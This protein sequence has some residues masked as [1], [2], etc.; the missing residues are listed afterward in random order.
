[1][2]VFYFIHVQDLYHSSDTNSLSNVLITQM[3]YVLELSTLLIYCTVAYISAFLNRYKYVKILN[4]VAS[5][6]AESKN[7]DDVRLK[8][9]GSL[10]FQVRYVA[11]GSLI[12]VLILQLTVNATRDDSL[13]KM[14]MVIFSFILPQMIQMI[15]LAFHYILVMM[16]VA[17]LADINQQ[18]RQLTKETRITAPDELYMKV[19]AKGPPFT[20]RRLQLVY[21]KAYEIKTDINEAFQA[22]LLISTLQCFHCIVSESY[23]IYHGLVAHTHTLHNTVNNSIWTSY[24]VMKVFSLAYSGRQLT[25]EASIR[26][27]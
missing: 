12:F 9:L 7:T 20:V 5:I 18:L 23:S 13:W 21:S 1:M 10:N 6:L 22:P 24:Q 17:L 14:T 16:L 27:S 15:G 25:L 11:M 8:I 19:N 26:Y 4:S 2:Y 3:N